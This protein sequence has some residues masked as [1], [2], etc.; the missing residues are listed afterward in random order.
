MFAH[1]RP[2]GVLALDYEVEDVDVD[3]WQ[4]SPAASDEPPPD[5]RR[6]AADGCDY[7]LRHRIVEIDR[8]GRAMTRELEA[9]QW[10]GAE[11]VAHETHSLVCSVWTR[12]D[13]VAALQEVGFVDVEVLGGYH[14]GAPRGDER[15][16]VYV[17]RHPS[18]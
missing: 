14:G 8:A 9:W 11:L 13:I 15:F 4:V 12:E 3:R 18:T 5:R 17:T 7:A 1:L 2:G 16:L 10:R 6:R